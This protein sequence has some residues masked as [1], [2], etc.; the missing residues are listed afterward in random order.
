MKHRWIK[1]SLKYDGTQLHS[2]FAY[3]RFG[4]AG[5]SIVAFRGPVEVNLTEMVDIED[6]RNKEPIAADEMLSFIVEVFD[7]ELRGAI[8]MQ[9]LLMSIMQNELNFRLQQIAFSRVG[10]DLLY[11]GRKLSVSIA[12]V[13][14]VS[15][16]IHSAVNI[17]PG[18]APISIACLD[19]M[20][21]DAEDF[22]QTVMRKF[23]AEFE[24]VEF[25]RVKVRW[26]K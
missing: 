21:V 5:N 8:W 6:V 19:E 15:A 4:I 14:P 10:D 25:A 3:Q 17:K 16:L 24:E 22:A 18:G 1:K 12:T 2:H 20:N 13:S 9:R 23:C 11:D 26:V 7:L